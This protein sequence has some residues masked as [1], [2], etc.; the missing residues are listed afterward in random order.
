MGHLDSVLTGR[1]SKLFSGQSCHVINKR[2]VVV[3]HI[4]Y[5]TPHLAKDLLQENDPFAMIVLPMKQ[6][7]WPIMTFCHENTVS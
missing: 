1:A 3:W 7:L 4:V 6:I 2:I 5:S